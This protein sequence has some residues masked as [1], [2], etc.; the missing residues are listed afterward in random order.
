M[1]NDLVTLAMNGGTFRQQGYAQEYFGKSLRDVRESDIQVI[2]DQKYE[3]SLTLEFKAIAS[4]EHP[5]ELGKEISAF[6]NS[7][8]GL[9]IVGLSEREENGGK[10]RIAARIDWNP[11]K[12]YTKEWFS[13]KIIAGIQP[14]IN[15]LDF[16]SM[17]SDNGA[18][19][20]FIVDVPA[21][22]YSPH[23]SCCDDHQY[24]ERI[25]ARSVPMEHYQV[26]YHFGRRLR[27]DLIPQVSI[28]DCIGPR[29]FK[30]AFRIRNDGRALAKWPFMKVEFFGCPIDDVG[31]E[32]RTH[33]KF[34]NS[35]YSSN[36]PFVQFMSSEVAIYSSSTMD[37]FNAYPFTTQERFVIRVSVSGENVV[38]KT[39][40]GFIYVPD[41]LMKLKA[42]QKIIKLEL[43]SEERPE[44]IVDHFTKI[45]S[46]IPIEEFNRDKIKRRQSFIWLFKAA[47]FPQESDEEIDKR[48]DRNYEP[49]D[50]SNPDNHS[51][52][53]DTSQVL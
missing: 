8:G 4:L 53:E 17:Q 19:N 44:D 7:S 5:A 43:I 38:S 51:S 13:Q 33:E 6:S 26:D 3:E 30:L 10:S 31:I 23:M 18:G 35:D 46:S 12:A 52:E 34:F 37:L 14:H 20:I 39:F 22:A 11:K 32:L 45:A 50:A 47:L 36:R 1:N 28:E 2:I 40:Y 21:S 9:L 48:V 16:I 15:D 49:E 27:P 41:A 42:G 24:Y 29:T 25:G